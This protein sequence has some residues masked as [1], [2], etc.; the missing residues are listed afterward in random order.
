ME[1]ESPQGQ[2]KGSYKRNNCQSSLGL[3]DPF[4]I[5]DI[6]NINWTTTIGPTLLP[7]IQS[8]HVARMIFL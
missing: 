2:A 3:Q 8:L 5:T 1:G 4:F 7:V 6:I